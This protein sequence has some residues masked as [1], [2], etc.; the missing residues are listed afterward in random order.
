MDTCCRAAGIVSS[1]S[2]SIARSKKSVLPRIDL[3]ARKINP[4]VNHSIDLAF[5]ASYGENGVGA[6]LH[7]NIMARMTMPALF[8]PAGEK[9]AFTQSEVD[10]AM[11]ACALERFRLAQGQYPEELKDLVPAFCRRSCPMTSSTASL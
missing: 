3:A 7:H 1:N 9:A 6:F 4:S 11:L 10:M 2:I 8:A 5:Q